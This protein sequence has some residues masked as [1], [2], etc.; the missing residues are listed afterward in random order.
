MLDRKNV[1]KLHRY[2]LKQERQR[3]KV[4]KYVMDLNEDDRNEFFSQGLVSQNFT[5]GKESFLSTSPFKN[6]Q[7]SEANLAKIT[8]AHIY[9]FEKENK[10]ENNNKI[11]EEDLK[12]AQEYKGKLR[13]RKDMENMFK[14]EKFE[15]EE[16][17][18]ENKRMREVRQANN[19]LITKPHPLR[20]T[21][22][23]EEIEMF[24][25]QMTSEMPTDV[26]ANAEILAEVVDNLS[27]TF[28]CPTDDVV[29]I[30]KTFPGGVNI[31]KV[32]SMLLVKNN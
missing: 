5:P 2:K 10:T 14:V 11:K 16:D 27:L 7:I 32:R 28:N 24:L 29:E 21:A 19:K 15:F 3:K 20:S 25:H 18:E 4:L 23:E 31:G 30:I 12:K 26:A 22:L 17:V 13:E 1:A 9:E 8:P 6:T